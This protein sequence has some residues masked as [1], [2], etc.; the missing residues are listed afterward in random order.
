MAIFD[1]KTNQYVEKIQE[2]IF[3]IVGGELANTWIPHITIGVYKDEKIDEIIKYT[4]EISLN[5]K[6]VRSS[7]DSVGQFMHNEKYKKTDVFCL[8]PAI[9]AGL[10]ELYKEYHSMYEEQLS[11]LGQDYRYVNGTPTI[12]CSLAICK[13]ENFM[14]V[15]S[16][17]HQNFERKEIN[18]IGIQIADMNKNLIAKFLFEG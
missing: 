14:K 16:Y 6:V 8:M 7:F 13:M 1:E 9:T 4:R 17:L 18:I 5:R 11:E 10:I 2:Q 15:I 12:H 3:K